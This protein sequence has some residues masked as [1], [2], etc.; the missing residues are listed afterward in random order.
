MK[1]RL[2]RTVFLYFAM[3]ACAGSVVAKDWRGIVPLKSTRADVERLLGKVSSSGYYN[4]PNEFISFYFQQ[5]PCDTFPETLGFGWNV[6]PGT[7]TEIG[8]IPKGV[9]RKDE[10]QLAKD[11]RVEDNGFGLVY[12]WDN[13]AGLMV[14]TYNG[15]VTL[16]DFFPKSSE[17]Q[18]RCPRV[19][20]CCIDFFSTFDEYGAI[21]FNDE[22]A[23]LD[24][25]AIQINALSGRGTLL[26]VGPSRKIRAQ[27]MKHAARGK[28]YLVKRRGLE[29]QRLLIIDGGYSTTSY[30]RLSVYPIGQLPLI[31][32]AGE[33]DPQ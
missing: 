31:Y 4:L 20:T 3:M 13:D 28:D 18:L 5:E 15:L 1:E 8:I 19:Q 21:A 2:Y 6:P 23:R 12:Y 30:T 32:F 29:P 17:E 16:V 10:Y 22:K 26:V 14:E 25:F 33:K 24:N 7:V 9:H 11:S 27:L